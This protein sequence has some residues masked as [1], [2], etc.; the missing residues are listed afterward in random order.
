M[1]EFHIGSLIQQ[2]GSDFLWGAFLTLRLSALSMT[3]GLAIGIVLAGLQRSRHR[4]IP[5]IAKAYVEGI[6]NTP[7]LVQ[8][9]LV[10]FGLPSLGPRLSPNEAAII[11]LALNAGAFCTEIIRAGVDSIQRGLIEAA[12]SLGLRGL[13]I[14]RLVILPPAVRAVYPALT[15]QFMLV[16][17]NTSVASAIA[18]D[19][20]TAVSDNLASTTFNTLGVY[21]IATAIYLVISLVFSFLFRV[22]ELIF[23]PPQTA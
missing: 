13:Q 15:S 11:A 18:A 14:F 2:Y 19:E 7:F 12:Q 21:L 5:R 1:G 9:Y 8:L 17:L 16:M 4:T 23:F 6:R 20:L 10:Y 22:G 3:I